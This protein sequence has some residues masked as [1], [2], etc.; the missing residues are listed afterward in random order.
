MKD[1]EVWGEAGASP[2]RAVNLE[3]KISRNR[4]RQHAH[5]KTGDSEAR[6]EQDATQNYR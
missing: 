5:R 6:S 4:P 3:E 2:P 1:V